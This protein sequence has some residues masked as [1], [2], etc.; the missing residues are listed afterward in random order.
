LTHARPCAMKDVSPRTYN[1]VRN[2]PCVQLFGAAQR[3]SAVSIRHSGACV[4]PRCSYCDRKCGN[5]Q[6]INTG[7]VPRSCKPPVKR[8]T[9]G[10]WSNRQE[11]IERRVAREW[12]GGDKCGDEEGINPTRQLASSGL[13]PTRPEKGCL[14]WA[15]HMPTR[16]P[17]AQPPAT[18]FGRCTEIKPLFA[19]PCTP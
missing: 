14:E 18:R 13:P 3:T 5:G 8:I 9:G 6:I 4:V 15:W 16:W 11:E 10:T 17:E 19:P 2:Q 1:A 7:N 12:V